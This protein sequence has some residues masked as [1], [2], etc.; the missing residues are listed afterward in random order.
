M[1]SK[2]QQKEYLD[3]LSEVADHAH[4]PEWSPRRQ[5]AQRRAGT[6][7]LAMLGESLPNKKSGK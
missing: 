4:R 1:A 5:A 6:A 2:D 7:L 3:S